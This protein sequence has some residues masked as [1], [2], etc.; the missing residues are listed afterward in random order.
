LVIEYN[1][2]HRQI[3]ILFGEEHQFPQFEFMINRVLD[4]EPKPRTICI[5]E[6]LYRRFGAHS[7]KYYDVESYELILNKLIHFYETHQE[8]Q[9]LSIF[10]EINN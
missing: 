9:L 5:S 1:R 6:Q 8:N 3:R 4:L 10:Q 7:K 2:E